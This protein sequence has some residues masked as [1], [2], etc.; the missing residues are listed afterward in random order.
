M[1]IYSFLSPESNEVSQAWFEITDY[2][3]IEM[4]EKDRTHIKDNFLLNLLDKM[5]ALLIRIE[6]ER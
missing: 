3:L 4:D 2:R 5:E 6:G 1:W